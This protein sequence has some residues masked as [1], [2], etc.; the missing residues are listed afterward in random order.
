ML[1]PRDALLGRLTDSLG[2]IMWK[3]TFIGHDSGVSFVVRHQ[4]L[5]DMTWDELEASEDPVALARDRLATV[6]VG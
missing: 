6:A 2:P 5:V 1:R 3:G 4:R